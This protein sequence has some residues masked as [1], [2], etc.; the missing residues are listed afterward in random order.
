MPS[1]LGF[2]PKVLVVSNSL[3]TGPL[4]A[5]SLQEKRFDVILEGDPTRTLRRWS[6]EAPNLLVLDINT[7]EPTIL[8][9][10]RSL[11]EES[12]VPVLLLTTSKPEEYILEAYDAGVDECIIKPL[13]PTMFH[14]KIKAWLRRSWSVPVYAMEPLRAGN[15]QLV[16]SDRMVS[17]GSGDA[18]RLTNLELRLLYL[19]MGRPGRT[20]SADELI[21]KVWGYSEE[22]DNTVLKNVIYRLRRKIEIDP[23]NPVIIQTVS[24]VG[25]KLLTE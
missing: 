3:T 17:I 8:N 25:Y 23:A 22:A 5:F 16:P 13:S 15:V 7:Q 12:V 4:W 2:S 21:Q 20:I 19:L 24:G 10:V 18:I 9:M 1:N 11:R 6:D 14:A